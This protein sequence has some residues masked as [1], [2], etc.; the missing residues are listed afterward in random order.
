MGL[1]KS[2]GTRTFVKYFLHSPHISDF[3][4]KKM[5][6]SPFCLTNEKTVR[7]KDHAFSHMYAFRGGHIISSWHTPAAPRY[8]VRRPYSTDMQRLTAF[9][10]GTVITEQRT[11][12]RE[13]GTE[14]RKSQIECQRLTANPQR[15][16]H[17]TLSFPQN[18]PPC[19]Q[20]GH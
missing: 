6:I 12:N 9:F 8:R 3:H 5:E 1:K 14:K 13:P 20:T 15:P 18:N 4:P 19:P 17:L 2:E 10:W 16:T 7:K 11:K